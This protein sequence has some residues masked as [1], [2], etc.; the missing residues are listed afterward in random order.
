MNCLSDWNPFWQATIFRN[1]W[2]SRKASD[3]KRCFLFESDEKDSDLTEDDGTFKL[4]SGCFR[5][6]ERSIDSFRKTL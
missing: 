6:L 4:H 5:S 1:P 2:L 3:L